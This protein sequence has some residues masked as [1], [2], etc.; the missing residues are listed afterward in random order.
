MGKYTGEKKLNLPMIE[1]LENS[2]ECKGWMDKI[3]IRGEK[4]I[5]IHTDN[6]NQ[7]A[8]TNELSTLD[9]LIKDDKVVIQE[10]DVLKTAKKSIQNHMDNLIKKEEDSIRSY[11]FDEIEW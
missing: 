11:Q 2:N 5:E 7:A 8:A 4:L 6:R 3:D 1:S 9:E 10:I